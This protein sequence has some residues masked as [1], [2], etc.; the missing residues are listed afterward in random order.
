LTSPYDEI[1]ITK[2]GIINLFPK[3]LTASYHDGKLADKIYSEADFFY[4][5]LDDKLQ[6]DRK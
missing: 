4:S 6:P 3:A 1:R 5:N 2:Y